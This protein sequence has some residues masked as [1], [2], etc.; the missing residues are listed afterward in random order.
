TVLAL[1]QS[2]PAAATSIRLAPADAARL[3]AGDVIAIEDRTTRLRWDAPRPAVVR[4]VRGVQTETGVIELEDPGQLRTDGSRRL[5]L[6]GPL[7]R[8]FTVEDRAQVR[9]WDG[10]DLLV[11]GVRYRLRDGIAFV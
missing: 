1:A 6:G 10:A 5:D 3:R 11:T 4:R 2:A 8:E 9:R 7:G